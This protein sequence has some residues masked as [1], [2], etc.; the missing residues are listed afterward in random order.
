MPMQRPEE[1]STCAS[2]TF[3]R[4]RYGTNGLGHVVRVGVVWRVDLSPTSVS[5]VVR[6][7]A[8]EVRED[9]LD[10][11]VNLSR[12]AHLV[13]DLHDVETGKCVGRVD[14]G[15]LEAIEGVSARFSTEGES[16]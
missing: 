12:A 7:L 14:V 8:L 6:D 3:L 9:T 4:K 5:Q 10:R 16:A 15:S 1:V 11:V 2:C 13:G